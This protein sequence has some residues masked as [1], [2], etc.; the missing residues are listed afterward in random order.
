[1]Q[2]V[3]DERHPLIPKMNAEPIVCPGHETHVLALISTERIPSAGFTKA[4]ATSTTRKAT[5]TLIYSSEFP[6][7]SLFSNP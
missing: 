1:M 6:V 5:V 2:T 3:G 4:K 7:V